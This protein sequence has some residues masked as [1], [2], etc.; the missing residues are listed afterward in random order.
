MPWKLADNSIKV[1]K[2]ILIYMIPKSQKKFFY[3]T[4]RPDLTVSEFWITFKNIY[5]MLFNTKLCYQQ[6]GGVQQ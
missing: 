1:M 2:T 4:K 6:Y 3:F 5:I